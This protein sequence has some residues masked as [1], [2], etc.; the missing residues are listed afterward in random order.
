MIFRIFILAFTLSTTFCHSQTV[1]YADILKG[2][3]AET[4]I[5]LLNEASQVFEDQLAI[6]YD[7]QKLGQAYRSFLEDVQAMN[8]PPKFFVTTESKKIMGKLESSKAFDQIWTKLSSVESYEE[9]QI[10]TVDGPLAIVE[11][12]FD[13]YAINPNGGYITCLFKNNES[14]VVADYLEAVIKD[15]GLS[16]GLTASWLK[17][18]L[19]EED[20]NNGLTRLIMAIGFYYE[21][22]LLLQEMDRVV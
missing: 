6:A 16:P 17:D 3:L 1:G 13:S 7:G 15:P 9:I 21:I 20:F 19:K 22:M 10:F 11:D 2:C 18:N 12:E 8:L 4:D 14:Q 5:L